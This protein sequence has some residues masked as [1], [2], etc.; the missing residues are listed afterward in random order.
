MQNREAESVKEQSM[1]RNIDISID[2]NELP[3][4][5][6]VTRRSVGSVTVKNTSN[7]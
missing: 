3:D 5:V 6:T 1:G 4:G 2:T 7:A